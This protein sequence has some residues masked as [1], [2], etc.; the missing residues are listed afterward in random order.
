MEIFSV[1]SFLKEKRTDLRNHHSVL[2]PADRFSWNSVYVIMSREA[3]PTIF[4]FLISYNQQQ[5]TINY[6][7][8]YDSYTWFTYLSVCGSTALVGLGR[9]F[10]FL[11]LYTVGRTP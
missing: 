10:S 1:L 9:L 4:Y 11:N 2:Q 3:F 6:I 5:N 8:N 7:I